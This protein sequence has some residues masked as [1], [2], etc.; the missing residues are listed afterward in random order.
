MQSKQVKINEELKNEMVQKYSEQEQ[1]IQQY[2]QENEISKADIRNQLNEMQP[3]KIKI[4]ENNTKITELEEKI[5]KINESC[6][7]IID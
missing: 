2:H 3:K 7:C 1:L 4:N 5:N 6:L